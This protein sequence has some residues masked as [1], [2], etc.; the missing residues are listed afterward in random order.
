M[1]M[2]ATM[3]ASLTATDL[4]ASIRF[5]T[6][7]LGF[8]IKR[9]VESDGALRFVEMEAGGAQLAV[10]RDDFALG[11]DRKKGVGL[12]FWFRTSQDIAALAAQVKAA[13]ITL[14]GEPAP[15]PWGPLAFQVTDPDGFKITVSQG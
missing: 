1:D 6:E 11:R 14:D 4:Q 13:G 2:N 3:S 15:L 8:T 12:R 9:S 7:G 5:Y 10:G